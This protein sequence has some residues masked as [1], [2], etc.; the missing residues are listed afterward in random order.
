MPTTKR[1]LGG[2]DSED[3]CSGDARAISAGLT[4]SSWHIR[5]LIPPNEDCLLLISPF[6]RFSTCN[7][8]VEIC[9]EHGGWSQ[10][11]RSTY[12]FATSDLEVD[13]VP[14]LREY[15]LRVIS[16]PLSHRNCTTSG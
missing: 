9:E 8:V 1:K 6:M 3:S 16:P 5:Y 14:A 15:L 7:R 12:P 13:K 10:D 11:E 2:G 4:D